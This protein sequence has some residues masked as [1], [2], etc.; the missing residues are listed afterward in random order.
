MARRNRH[1]AI[2]EKVLTHLKYSKLAYLKASDNVNFSEEKRFF[3]KQALIRNQIF[4]QVLIE[5][6]ML[7]VNFDDLIISKFNFDQLLVS[8]IDTFK[9]N[10]S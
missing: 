3:N 4:Q 10:G 5:L 6:Q 8:S 7:D 2:I 1:I 9:A